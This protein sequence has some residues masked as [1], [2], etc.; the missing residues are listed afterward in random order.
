M[1]GFVQIMEIKTSRIDELEALVKKMQEERGDSLL[2]T[3]AV[4]T[5]DRDRPG[6][7]V[8][9]IEFNSYEE[10]MKNSNDPATSEFAKEMGALLEGPP[11]FYNL[12][13]RHE[14]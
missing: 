6:Y 12:D 14:M 11:K 10:A 5:A 7:Y 3:R 13:V 2:S 8:N 9:I 4:L 1:P